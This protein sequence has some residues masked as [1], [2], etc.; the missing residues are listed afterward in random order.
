MIKND[1]RR[2]QRAGKGS[3]SIILPKDWCREND[4]G[5]GTAMRMTEEVAGLLLTKVI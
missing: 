4:I 1:I 5:E 3:L 2:V